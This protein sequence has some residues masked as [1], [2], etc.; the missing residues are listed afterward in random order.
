MSKL[1]TFQSSRIRLSLGLFSLVGLAVVAAPVLGQGVNRLRPVKEPAVV[2]PVQKLVV[3]EEQPPVEQP[4]RR[5]TQVQPVAYE[6]RIPQQLAVGTGASKAVSAAVARNI[7]PPTMEVRSFA[8]A[9]NRTVRSGG[10]G[11]YVP[12]HQRQGVARQASFEEETSIFDKNRNAQLVKPVSMVT[13]EVIAGP[14]F[15]SEGEPYYDGGEGYAGEFVDGDMCGCEDG[16]MGCG[17]GCGH[18]GCCPR[19]LIPM[20]SF[21]NLEAFTGVQGFTGPMNRGGNGSFG[22]SEGINWGAAM[23]FGLAGQLGMRATQNNLDGSLITPDDR[24][25]M[26]VTGGFFRRVDLGLQGG[27]VF[28]YMHQDWDYTSDLNQ[29]RGELSWKMDCGHEFGFWFAAHGNQ[30]TSNI[31]FPVLPTTQNNL[32]ATSSV[33]FASTST[34]T[35]ATN[36][37]SF[38]YRKQWANCGE[39]RVFGGWTGDDRGLV[40]F[41]GYV[42]LSGRLGLST[43]VL[44]LVPATTSN[45]QFMDETWN[46]S[47]NLVWSR[48]GSS[49]G[50]TNYCRPLF[51]VGN[52]GNFLVKTTP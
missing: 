34:T 15:V 46:V 2:A 5:D 37:Y 44:Y 33:R 36:I 4:V 20:P 27:L 8:P 30:Q 3:A 51:D 24:T 49:R 42:P 18:H 16:G 28:D 52:N 45:R 19:C 12:A 22:F 38:F 43:N 6:A 23:P 1:S 31:N 7:A 11:G 13:E 41:D 39:G 32:G 25:Q 29:L 26:F 40:G 48:Q 17:L 14:N 50:V 35:Q 9:Q 21:S 47:I 10:V